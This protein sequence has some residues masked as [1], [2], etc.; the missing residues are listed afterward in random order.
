MKIADYLAQIRYKYL[1][2]HLMGELLQKSWID[3][4][5]PALFLLLTCAVFGIALPDFF[6]FGNI[7]DTGR[8]L[9]E[10]GFLALG[11]TIVILSGGIDLSVGAIFGLTNLATVALIMGFGLPAPVA[12]IGSLCLGGAVG[13]V[14]GLLVGYM[15]MRAFL[16]TLAVLIIGRSALETLSLKYS[17]KLLFGNGN[18]D[19]W[20]WFGEGDI[21]GIPVSLVILLVVTGLVHIFLTRMRLGWHIQA[22]GGS[23]RS[24]HNAGLKVNSI[25]CFAYVISGIFAGMAGFLYSART[26][27]P[28]ADVGI[29]FEI[30]ALT[31]AILGGNSLGGGRGSASKAVIGA[32]IV[33]LIVNSLVAMGL[34]SGGTNLVL[35]V[36]LLL[37]VIIDVRWVKNRQKILERVYL[38]PKFFK[39]APLPS[40]DKAEATPFAINNALSKASP[41]GQGKLDGPEDVIFDSKD[42]L[43]TGSRSGD[44]IRFS[45]PDYIK[46][47]LFAHVGGQTL[48]MAMDKED[49]IHVCVSGMGVYKVTQSRKVVKLCDQV[50]RSKFSIRDDS[51][52]R[53]A[54]DL[55]IASDGK[56]YFSEST[57]RFD[58][59]DWA[60]DSL[61]MRG[62]GRII[63]YDPKTDQSKVVLPNLIFPNGICVE[64]N[65]ESLLFAERW[66]GTVSRFWFA[67]SKKGKVDPVLPNLPGFTDNINR[68]SDGNYYVAIIGVR[69][70]VHDLAMEMPGFRK[71]MSQRVAPDEWL[72]PNFNGGMIIK[73]SPAGKI[74]ECLWDAKGGSHATLSSMA[75]HHGRLYL[76]GVFNNQI[77]V[78]NL[79]NADPNWSMQ[80]SYWGLT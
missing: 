75:E 30:I 63:C 18:Y 60:S 48:G 13:L 65:G 78:I 38:A 25:V 17:S 67:G 70:P 12:L 72:Y 50:P 59:H 11:M 74:L 35:G 55:D 23:R 19:L 68:T 66:S 58:T 5:I 28:G 46:Q 41:I 69:T 42:N 34:R 45:P 27:N 56:V 80:K 32:L 21:F 14:N 52:V 61:E 22:I 4:A 3:T 79:P 16:T 2:D 15:G 64:G 33:I 54:D 10:V 36:V 62:N 6:S 44:I 31:A 29:G 26:S 53:F 51:R 24:A 7:S 40:V 37:A 43:Y 9:G 39:P 47:D 76:G 8:Q 71:R 20:Y 49:A 73:F 57:V 1:P 77:G